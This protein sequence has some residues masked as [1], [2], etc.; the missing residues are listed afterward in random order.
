MSNTITLKPK[1]TAPTNTVQVATKPHQ[2]VFDQLPDSA[3]VREAQLVRKTASPDSTAPLP[4]SAPTL[5]R[6]V[7]TGKFPAPTKLSARVTCWRVGAVR[8]WMN[9]QA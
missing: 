6:M 1:P 2:S 3:F 5:W 4:F 9:S 8:A 7:R